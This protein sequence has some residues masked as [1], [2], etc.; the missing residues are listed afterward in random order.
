MRKF[1]APVESRPKGKIAIK[2]PFDPSAEWGE[3]A[4]HHVTGSVYSVPVR[5]PLIREGDAYYLELGPAWNRGRRPPV[6]SSVEVVLSPEGPQFSSLAKDFADALGAEP[7]ARAFFESLAT[8]YREGF[9]R[10]IEE[11]KRP[12]TRSKRIAETIDALKAGRKSR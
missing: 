3:K 6:G 1:S 5:G 10:W 7:E 8:F 9:V 4:I 12:D 2:V 11:A